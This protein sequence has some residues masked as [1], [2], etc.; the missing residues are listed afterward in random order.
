MQGLET[1]LYY[2]HVPELRE[3]CSGTLKILDK[4]AKNL[5]VQRVVAYLRHY[6][7]EKPV[8]ASLRSFPP[9]AGRRAGEDAGPSDRFQPTR[10]ENLMAHKVYKNDARH[11]EFFVR[12]IGP[13]FHFTAAGIEW[14]NER[15][16]QGVRPTFQE[17]IEYWKETNEE[18]KNSGKK[19]SAGFQT[20]QFNQFQT[21]HGSKGW[22]REKLLEEWS[23]E[24]TE[25]KKLALQ[26]VGEIL[27]GRC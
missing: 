23:K 13:Q 14:L 4:G 7:R 16:L 3:V 8:L 9:E 25:K 18:L 27:A 5:L 15:W 6:P 24:R 12:Q 2:L 21:R 19:P 10:V 22:N 17:Y 11:R 20:L 1:A 26:I